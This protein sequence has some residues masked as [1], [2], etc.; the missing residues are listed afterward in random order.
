M[1]L[2]F[3]ALRN[4]LIERKTFLEEL[5]KTGKFSEEEAKSYIDA[6]VIRGMFEQIKDG[7]YIR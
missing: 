6:A 4:P 2:I 1:K 7:C 5:L 3:D